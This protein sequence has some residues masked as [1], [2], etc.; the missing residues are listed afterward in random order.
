MS[1]TP[2]SYVTSATVFVVVTSSTSNMTLF[3]VQM[4]LMEVIEMYAQYGSTGTRARKVLYENTSKK[5]LKV[6]YH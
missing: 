4:V 5:K 3:C 1:T 2:S 6:E